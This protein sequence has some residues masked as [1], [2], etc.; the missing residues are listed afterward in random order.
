MS[1][2]VDLGIPILNAANKAIPAQAWKASEDAAA[3]KMSMSRQSPSSGDRVVEEGAGADV[4]ALPDMTGQ[5]VEEGDGADE[6]RTEMF[7]HQGLF[8]ER[9]AHESQVELFE[10]AQAAMNQLAR[11]GSKC[12]KPSLVARS[13]QRTD[14]GWL[15]RGPFPRRPRHRQRWRDR[16]SRSE[17]DPGLLRVKRGSRRAGFIE[18]PFS[19]GNNSESG[20]YTIDSR[21]VWLDLEMRLGG[22]D[23]RANDLLNMIAQ[24]TEADRHTAWQRA[25]VAAKIR[26]ENSSADQ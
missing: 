13:K 20:S 19:D 11:G 2:I 3:R 23:V 21:S 15:H 14:H 24:W 6:M 26:I 22:G 16:K 17:C 5:R 25:F 8:A 4:G 18:V 10:V 9:F 7:E 1:R 12:P